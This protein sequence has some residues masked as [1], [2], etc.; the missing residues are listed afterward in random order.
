MA[1]SKVAAIASAQTKLRA[2]H[3]D[4]VQHDVGRLG[5]PAYLLKTAAAVRRHRGRIIA[6]RWEP[7]AV[8]GQG[9]APASPRC[10]RRFGI[11]AQQARLET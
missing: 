1:S 6:C 5:I 11:Q 10:N 7:R 2:L 4:A 8:D 9:R 3:W